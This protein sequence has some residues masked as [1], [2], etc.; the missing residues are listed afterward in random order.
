[1]PSCVQNGRKIRSC[2]SGPIPGPVSSTATWMFP[3]SELRCRPT[4]PAVR[5]PAERVREQ[6]R[7]DLQDAVAVGH[8]HRLGGHLLRVVDLPLLRLLAEREVR[9]LEQPG[10]VDLLVADRE[11]P[12]VELREVEHV[13]DEPLEPHRLGG[14]HV[15]RGRAQRRVVDDSLAERLDV[16]ADRGQRRAQLVR[17][18]HQ[19]VALELLGLG[20]A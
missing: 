12:R 3:F 17:D 11:A 8:D 1:M 13:A 18:G 19:E 15:E 7:D 5:R 16:P 14:D 4:L 10:H 20:Q 2:S 6:V 9:L